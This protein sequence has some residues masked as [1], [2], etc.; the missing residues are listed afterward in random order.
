MAEK[1]C[2]VLIHYD[3]GEPPQVNELRKQLETGSIEVKAEALKSAIL[4][5][6]N[7]ESLNNLLMT[8]IRF[9]MPI[10]DHQIKKLLLMYWEIVDKQTAEGKPMP[11]MILVW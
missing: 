4:L 2:T 7:G 8:I 9:V 3:K 11:E 1:T 5:M 10:D 6:L